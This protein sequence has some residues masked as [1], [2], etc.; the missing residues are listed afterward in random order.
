M[1]AAR[2]P[3]HDFSYTRRSKLSGWFCDQE[4]FWIVGKLLNQVAQATGG[5]TSFSQRTP[6]TTKMV[7][8]HAKRSIE[9]VT[10][11]LELEN[12]KELAKPRSGMN[13]N[14]FL[15]AFAVDR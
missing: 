11:I 12:N 13:C 9:D 10:A 15:E 7:T 8:N 14:T 1:T 4:A 6:S 3:V 2:C 5:I